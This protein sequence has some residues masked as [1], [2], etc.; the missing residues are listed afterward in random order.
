MGR[1]IRIS[2][3]AFAAMMLISGCSKPD[4]GN[5]INDT[6]GEMFMTDNKYVQVIGSDDYIS[7]C[8]YIEND[9]IMELG[10]RLNEVEEQAYMNGYN[11]D[12]LI[13]Y[14]V[15][16]NAPELLVGF[17]SDPEAGMYSGYYDNTDE[18][19]AKAEKLSECILKMI[20][21]PDGLCEFV[22]DN[23]DDIPWD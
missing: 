10:N 2:A 9:E 22:S 15:N 3:A 1:Y 6:T 14:Y 5:N 18:N 20:E 23:R 12:A 11:W 7:V 13:G 19:M 21:D 17:E 8:F 4:E 16:V